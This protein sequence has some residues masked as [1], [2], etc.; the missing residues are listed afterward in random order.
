MRNREIAVALH[1]SPRSVEVYPSRIY[2]KPRV[3]SRLEPA[4]ALDTMD[5]R[6]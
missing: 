2:A 6:P 4:R 5:A 1:Y 3:S